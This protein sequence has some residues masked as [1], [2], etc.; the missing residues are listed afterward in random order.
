ME[1]VDSDDNGATAKRPR[2]RP[3]A[4]PDERRRS[5]IIDVARRTFVELGYMGTTTDIVAARCQISKQTLYRLFTSKSELFLAVVTAHRQMMLNLPR[6]ADEEGDIEEII[7]QI[8]MIDITEEQ[9]VERQAFVH[10]VMRDGTQIPEI[11]EVLK[12]EGVDRSRQIL[13]DWLQSQS[14]RDRLSIDD[15]LSSARMLMDMMFGALGRAGDQFADRASRR[16]HMERCIA[17]FVRGNRTS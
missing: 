4:R 14:D 17:V 9:D 15:P 11:Q 16:A 5:E 12:R 6:P 2:G 13:A 1:T 3:K 7:K 8:F 10:V